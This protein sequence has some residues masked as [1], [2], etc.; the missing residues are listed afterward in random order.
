MSYPKEAGYCN[1]AR[2]LRGIAVIN[3]CERTGMAGC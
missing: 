2:K 1:R 3:T